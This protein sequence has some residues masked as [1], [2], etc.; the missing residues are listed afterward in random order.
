V[1]VD[2]IVLKMHERQKFTWEIQFF[3]TVC[4]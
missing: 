3:I 1:N 2:D 4:T